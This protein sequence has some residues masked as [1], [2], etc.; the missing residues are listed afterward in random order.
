MGRSVAGHEPRQAFGLGRQATYRNQA[1][2]HLCRPRA[3]RVKSRLFDSASFP[4]QTGWGRTWSAACSGY[5]VH[6]LLC[7]VIE[8]RGR[9]RTLSGSPG[10]TCGLADRARWSARAR[11]EGHLGTVPVVETSTPQRWL[12]RA[13]D[14]HRLKPEAIRWS[15]VSWKQVAGKLLDRELVEGLILVEERRWPNR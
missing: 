13:G 12:L 5:S 3:P 8:E 14:V 15:S 7:R 4:G 6:R 1:G 10:R 9:S 2:R 11:P